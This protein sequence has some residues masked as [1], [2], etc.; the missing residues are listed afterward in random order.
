MVGNWKLACWPLGMLALGFYTGLQA[1][2]FYRMLCPLA[3]AALLQVLDSDTIVHAVR[4]FQDDQ[5]I[6][7]R[8][9]DLAL[10]YLF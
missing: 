6:C 1:L 8:A 10:T 7:C 3:E 4:N 9:L 2:G 5:S